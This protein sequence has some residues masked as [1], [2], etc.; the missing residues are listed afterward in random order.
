MSTF[1]VCKLREIKLFCL[2]DLPLLW[3]VKAEKEAPSDPEELQKH[4][5]KAAKEDHEKN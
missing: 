4:N 1:I 3:Q 2:I 5:E